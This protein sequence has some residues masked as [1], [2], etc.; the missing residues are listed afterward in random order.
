MKTALKRRPL[1]A[2]LI[3]ILLVLAVLATFNAPKVLNAGPPGREKEEQLAAADMDTR[4]EVGTMGGAGGGLMAKSMNAAEYKVREAAPAAAPVAT[5]EVVSPDST[6]ANPQSSLIGPQLKPQL[7]KEANVSMKVDKLPDSLKQVK[8]LVRQ[9]G[10]YVTMENMALSDEQ[11]SY[12]SAS[13]TLRLPQDNLD[14]FL[15]SAGSVG[16]ILDERISATDVSKELVD[17][18]SRIKN[19]Q[20]QEKALQAIMQRSGKIAEVLEVADKLSEVRGEIESAQGELRF[21]KSQVAYSTVN[22]SLSEKVVTSAAEQKPGLGTVITNGLQRAWD[23][24]YAFVLS[25]VSLGIW[26]LL[27]FLPRLLL[28]GLIAIGLVKL[29]WVVSAPLR[30][31]LNIWSREKDRPG[32]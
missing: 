22:L 19:L 28:L 27:S 16:K 25:L 17:T 32:Q 9:L 4:S 20:A 26:L 14:R 8:V 23:D 11:G 31:R 7:I 12:R 5:D 1:W 3:L 30:K 29:V 21:M 2:A 24:F 6:P 10:G 18:A 15:E 13:L